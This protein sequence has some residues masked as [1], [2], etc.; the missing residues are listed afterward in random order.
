MTLKTLTSIMA[1]AWVSVA[2]A[3]SSSSGDLG[4]RSTPDMKSGPAQS[5]ANARSASLAQNAVSPG[6]IVVTAQR[7]SERWVDV[8]ISIAAV[9]PS[10]L[11]QAGPTSLENLTKVVPGAY[12]QRAVY[13]LSPTIRGIGSTLPASGGE[14][15]VATYIDGV[16]QATPTGNIFDLASVSD[17]EVLKGPQGTLFGRNATGGALLIKT[18]DPS[19]ATSGRFNVSYERF[20]QVRASGYLNVPINDKIAVNGAISYRYARGYIRDGRTGDYVNEGRNFT[21]RGKLLLQPTDN[22]SIILTASHADF[23][24]PTGSNYQSIRLTGL[25]SLPFLD[26]GPVSKDRYH[27]S[28]NTR[29]VIKTSTDEYSAHAKLDL[30]FG[31]LTSISA[32]DVNDLFSI[33]DLDNTY[34]TIPLVIPLPLP[35]GPI[36]IPTDQ[37]ATVKV[38]TKT[39]TQELNLTSKGDGPLSYVAGLYYYHSESA[40]P[41]LL[42][43][44]VPL[45]NAFGKNNAYAAY[46]EGTYRLGELSLIAGA[47]YSYEK[48]LGESAQGVSAPSPFTRIQNATDKKWTPRIGLRYALSPRA[49]IYATYSKGFKSGVFDLSSPNGPS[50]KPETVDAFE[51][52]FKTS[53]KMFSLSAAGFYYDYKDSQ[54]NSTVSGQDGAIF[55]QLFNVPTSRIYGIDIDGTVRFSDAFDVRAGFAY[56]HARYIDF[57]TAPGYTNDPTVPATLGGLFNANIVVDASGSHMVRAPAYTASATFGYHAEVGDDSRLD[58]TVSPYYSSRVYFDFANTLSQKAY[59]TLDAAVTFTS[60]GNMTISVFGRNLTDKIYYT[61]QG[62]NALGTNGNFG[63]PRTYGVSLGYSF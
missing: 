20:N 55:N 46:A 5:A 2:H 3:Q 1:I 59:M 6:D 57:K 24:D 8:P 40:V 4:N 45:F 10:A 56:T 36:V 35:I 62:I 42:S 61:Q 25:Y 17:V 27:L 18:L 9:S 54:V 22:F 15:N 26:S 31:T 44:D 53:S 14:Q 63:M 16:Y 37:S 38:H 33:N 51:A 34:A 12:F 21:A 48:R 28:H 13:G 39:F 49:N 47:R 41:L 43:N 58:V 23:D 19:F 11:E 29:D 52:G 30:D 60:H 7:R 32:Y 50:V